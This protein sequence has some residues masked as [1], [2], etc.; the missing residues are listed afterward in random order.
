MG[1]I[2]GS[3]VSNKAKAQGFKL[4]ITDKK[5]FSAIRLACKG[6]E[7]NLGECKMEMNNINCKHDQDVVLHLYMQAL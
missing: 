4:P 6:E 1:F 3:I 5:G 2:D 7:G